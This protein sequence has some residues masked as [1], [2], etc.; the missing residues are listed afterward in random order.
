MLELYLIRH[1]ESKANTLA[2]EFVGGRVVETPL[3][4]RG[5]SQ[6][7][8][9]AGNLP[10]FT[11]VYSSP[12]VRTLQTATYAGME[13]MIKEE[14][15]LERSLGEWEGKR[16]EEVYTPETMREIISEGWNYCPPNGESKQDV[17][18]RLYEWLNSQDFIATSKDKKIALFTHEMVIKA[19]LKKALG[20]S[21]DEI[22]KRE[23]DNASVT[24]FKYDQG[25][26][27]PEEIN[28]TYAND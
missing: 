3:S 23:I 24:N 21:S 25:L 14:S 10:E 9:L 17:E 19:F 28:K 1:A 18:N 11:D 26:W 22:F 15:L 2:K 5:V 20:E 12:A 7:K 27:I 8:A 6:A 4:K 16:T 13:E